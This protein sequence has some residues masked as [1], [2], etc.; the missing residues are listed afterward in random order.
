MK[1][2]IHDFNFIDLDAPTLTTRE[3]VNE[4]TGV[5]KWSVW[6]RYCQAWHSHGAGEGH[7]EAHCTE[8]NS[9]YVAI[10][11]NLTLAACSPRHSYFPGE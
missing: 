11:Y 6:C 1:V 2:P 10:G 4:E 3:I 9:P 8:R 7:R 5:V